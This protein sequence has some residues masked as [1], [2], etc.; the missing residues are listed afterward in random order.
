MKY[1]CNF[2]FNGA[3]LKASNDKGIAFFENGFWV[4]KYF[5][6]C[7]AS[8]SKYWISPSQI[9]YIEKVDD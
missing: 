5:E 7:V 3:K 6:I 8:R 2:L 4:D 1:I 9:L